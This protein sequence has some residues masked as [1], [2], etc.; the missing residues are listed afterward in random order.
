[1]WTY[2]ASPGFTWHKKH[3]PVLRVDRHLSVG[4][5]HISCEC[6]GPSASLGFLAHQ[7]LQVCCGRRPLPV[8]YACSAVVPSNKTRAVTTPPGLSFLIAPAKQR[9]SLE[10]VLSLPSP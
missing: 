6:K 3:V 2:T 4:L 10:T 5:G 7:T 8:A 9:L 1:M